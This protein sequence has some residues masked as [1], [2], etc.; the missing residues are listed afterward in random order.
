MAIF[1]Y[2]SLLFPYTSFLISQHFNNGKMAI[3]MPFFEILQIEIYSVHPVII[4]HA[5][6]N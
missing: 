1:P 2:L 4:V 5:G 3:F 6:K